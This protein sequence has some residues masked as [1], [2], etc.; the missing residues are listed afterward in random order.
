MTAAEGSGSLPNDLADLD[1][2]EAPQVRRFL[3]AI[4]RPREHAR[5]PHPSSGA[6]MTT[7]LVDRERHVMRFAWT[8][9]ELN[10]A[11]GSVDLADAETVQLLVDHGVHL[12]LAEI[13][14]KAAALAAGIDE[15][16]RRPAD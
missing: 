15:A 13:L 1:D 9:E 12:T 10:V 2:D 14:D 16:A 5:G 3:E 7:R 4:A 8:C 6:P 11:L